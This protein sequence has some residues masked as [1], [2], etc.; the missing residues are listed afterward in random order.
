MNIA[1]FTDT[2]YP[3]INGVANSVYILKKE[4]EQLGH[5]VYV[6]TTTTPGSPEYEHNVFRVPSIP[7]ALIT[8]RR[9][10]LFYQP[11]L[12]SIIKKLDLD[13]IHT[14]TE[15]SLGIFGRLMT[16]EL[17]IPM[18]HTYHT[19][20]EDYTH[21]LTNF[22]TL[23]RRAKAFARVFTKICCN[24]VEQVIVP[25]K[26]VKDL[27][28]NYRVHKQISIV[29]TGVDLKK[30]DPELYSQED[31]EQLKKQYQIDEHDKVMLYLGRVSKE[32][33]IAEI[34]EA[35]PEYMSKREN[36][37]FVIVGS[38]PEMDILKQMVSER[39]LEDKIIFTGAQ[40]W[41]NIG[42]FYQIGDVFV[43]GST[44][45]TQG[46]TYIEAMAAGLPVVARK[47]RC[48][49]DILVPGWNGYDFVDKEGLL[50]GLD[51]VLFLNENISYGENARKNV[52]KLSTESFAKNV[53]KVYEEVMEREAIAKKREEYETK[54]IKRLFHR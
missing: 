18:V 50:A 41:D 40:P 19:I 10:G 48:L 37:K 14:H 16:R 51:A 4:L 12:A 52:Q 25:T 13:L 54:K 8:E 34:I 28:I 53:V 1:L 20:Y 31:V 47:D 15:F 6:F 23:D 33:N 36:V 45:E 44:S 49:D 9:V 26:K 3:E 27:L 30:F 42:L 38:G 43:S 35:M 5:T 32:K 11:K 17:K 46:L 7:F 39:H 24:T 2:Y 22:K 21:Y 29:P